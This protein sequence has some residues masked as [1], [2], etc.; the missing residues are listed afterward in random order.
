M[1]YVYKCDSCGNQFDVIKSV[2]RYQDPENCKCGYE[3]TRVPF[4]QRTYLSGTAVQDRKWNHALGMDCTESEARA[5]AK[6]NG[7]IE[8]GNENVTKEAKRTQ[9]HIEQKLD[10][11]LETVWKGA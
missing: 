5:Y 8:V 3:A 10:A 1:V 11:D 2:S 9:D 4:P 7:L 6:Q